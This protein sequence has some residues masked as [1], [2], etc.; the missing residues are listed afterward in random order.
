MDQLDPEGAALQICC[1]NSNT[2]QVATLYREQFHVPTPG[3]DS[4]RIREGETQRLD[5][6]QSDELQLRAKASPRWV[7]DSRE[8]LGARRES[9]S[10][11][12]CP[13][14]RAVEREKDAAKATHRSDAD[15]KPGTIIHRQAMVLQPLLAYTKHDVPIVTSAMEVSSSEVKL[16]LWSSQSVEWS[17]LKSPNAALVMLLIGWGSLA[18][19]ARA[20]SKDGKK[21][22]T[23]WGC[24]L[25]RLHAPSTPASLFRS[26]LDSFFL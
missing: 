11:R 26:C 6:L 1:P 13:P 2:R 19:L 9:V 24:A 5:A 22:G 25:T 3:I 18:N 14:A 23:S 20:L 4:A 12:E 16:I 17:L 7:R 21:A 15:L 10:E 8:L